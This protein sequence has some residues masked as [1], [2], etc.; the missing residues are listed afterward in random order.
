MFVIG[1]STTKQ[2]TKLLYRY[3]LLLLVLLVLV[4][5]V[6]IVELVM[7]IPTNI[8]APMRTTTTLEALS[9]QN[10]Q[11]TMGNIIP[12]PVSVESTGGTFALKNDT[13]IYVEAGSDELKNI[14]QY[15]ADKLKP[16][17]GYGLQIETTSETPAKN[18][19]Y[20]T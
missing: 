8:L 20:L 14:G 19:I 5:T 9:N 17:T 11:S 18:N 3:M 15:L 4:K 13:K 6:E 10:S 1:L 2:Q 12:M 7:G 16:A